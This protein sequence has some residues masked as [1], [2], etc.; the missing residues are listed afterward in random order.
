MKTSRNLDG[1]LQTEFDKGDVGLFN[2]GER[3]GSESLPV[4]RGRI[5]FDSQGVDV[6]KAAL[7]GATEA[8]QEKFWSNSHRFGF[9]G[10]IREFTAQWARREGVYQDR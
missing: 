1:S 8:E 5:V 10:R 2:H 9:L 3:L 7:D 4:V 6:L